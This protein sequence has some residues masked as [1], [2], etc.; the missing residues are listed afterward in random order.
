[1][2]PE[3]HC[4]STLLVILIRILPGY[5]ALAVYQTWPVGGILF[6]GWPGIPQDELVGVTGNR[7]ACV[8]LLPHLLPE[9]NDYGEYR[10]QWKTANAHF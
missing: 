5:L 9:N 8:S 10:K 3:V 4:S 1:M 2:V 6:P 7:E